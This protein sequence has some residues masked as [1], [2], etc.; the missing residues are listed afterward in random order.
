MV[1]IISQE[2]EEF[3]GKF[4]YDTINIGMIDGF[5]IKVNE[6]HTYTVYSTMGGSDRYLFTTETKQLC[7]DA[8]ESIMRSHVNNEGHIVFEISDFLTSPV[9]SLNDKESIMEIILGLMKRH[10]YDDI[11]DKYYDIEEDE[12]ESN[13][14]TPDIPKV[15]SIQNN[16]GPRNQSISMQSESLTVH[17]ALSDRMYV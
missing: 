5:K 12:P 3:P 4:V 7:N 13:D 1:F 11:V 2:Y 10:G 15:A 14:I 16:D 9:D 8:I 17:A 6:D